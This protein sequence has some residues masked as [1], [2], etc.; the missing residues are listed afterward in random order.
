MAMDHQVVVITGAASGLGLEMS[1]IC[2]KK[3][4]NVVMV[5]RDCTALTEQVDILSNQYESQILKVIADVSQQECMNLL[6]KKTIKRFSK[7]NWLINNAGITNHL[8]PLWELSN[9]HIQ[10][11]IDVNLFGAIN[12]I[13]AFLPFMFKQQ[14]QSHIINI[15]S[16][17]GLCSSS[18]VSAYSIS[19]HAVVS[20][21]ESLYFDLKRLKKPI[22]VSVVC[23]SFVNT[24]LLN[25][26]FP[27][28]DDKLHRIMSAL[29]ERSRPAGEVAAYIIQEIMKKKFYILPDK[30]VKD[31]LSQKI[32]S[33]IKES[34]PH[35]HSL[36]KL[37]NSLSK[38]A[39]ET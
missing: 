34:D 9:E 28:H 25:N 31:Y 19:K 1:Q 26:S 14:H 24:Q 7:I 11:V 13:K 18:Q 21:S 6:A 38:K 17:Y 15:A 37:I 20:L 35:I 4:M 23:P 33:I 8:A 30:E 2:L 27:L 29:L 32:D 36:E 5:D 16:V 39:V 3:N 12:G 22:N 10:K